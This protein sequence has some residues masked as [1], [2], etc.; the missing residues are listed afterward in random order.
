M[1]VTVSLPKA[2]HRAEFRA[3]S[4]EIGATIR[5]GDPI[6]SFTHNEKVEVM[7]ST[8]SGVLLRILI[9]E[10]IECETGD[11]IALLG[12]AGEDIGYDPKQIEC[13][14]IE[15]LNKCSEC[16]NDYPLNGLVDEIRCG[17]CGD[18]QVLGKTFWHEELRE[19]VEFARVPG[20]RGGGEVLGG[21][22]IEC[23]GFPP[24]CRKCGNLIPMTSLTE[25]WGEAEKSG[26][27]SIECAHCKAAY[28][29]RKPPDWGR[30][31]F[32]G[33][34]FLFGE[35]TAA[36]SSEP[37]KPVVFKCPNCTAS[38]Q[39]GGE[40]RVVRCQ[41]CESDVFLPDELWQHFNPRAKKAAW[42]MLFE[43]RKRRR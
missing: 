31:V 37:P 27:A 21:P 24:F 10:P 15:L 20:A 38:L 14:R 5:E 42:W 32:E 12:N 8:A 6:A 39:I 25:A 41:Y 3:P 13:V 35:T 11:P 30:E 33:L 26:G 7:R 4:A 22:T 2:L 36:S 9:S 23:R 19:D 29:A 43:P 34:V 18:S 17:R 1:A 40:K 28:A 16:S